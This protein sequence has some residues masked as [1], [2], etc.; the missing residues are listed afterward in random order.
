MCRII[1]GTK[2]KQSFPFK[3]LAMLYERHTQGRMLQESQR[4]I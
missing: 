2:P 3:N 4:V 1:K